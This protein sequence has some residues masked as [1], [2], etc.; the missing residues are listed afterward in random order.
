MD[1]TALQ[2]QLQQAD[3][4][5]L[6]GQEGIAFQRKMIAT[7][8]QGGHDVTAARLF[9]SRLDSQ[10]ARHA[11]NRDRLFKQLDNSS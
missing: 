1:R 6:R 10:Q 7:L 3:R 5:L 9:L 2:R 8:Q 11:A 4:L